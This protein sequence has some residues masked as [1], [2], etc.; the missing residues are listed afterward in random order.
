MV[1][2]RRRIYNLVAELHRK[3]ATVLCKRYRVVVMPALG[4]RSMVARQERRTHKVTVRDM[5]SLAHGRLRECVLATMRR[6]P[7]AELRMPTEEYTSQT[8]GHVLKHF[9]ERESRESNE[10][11]MVVVISRDV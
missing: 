9:C 3:C 4:T 6:Y 8:C 10:R 1:R 2:L 5:L 7:G 11:G